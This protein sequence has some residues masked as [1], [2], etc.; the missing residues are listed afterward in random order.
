MKVLFNIG[1][2]VQRHG[3]LGRYAEELAG[4]LLA[5]NTGDDLRLFYNDPSRRSPSPPL[6]GLPRQVLG[7]S[8]KFWRMSA[9]ISCYAHISMDSLLGEADVFHATDHLLPRLRRMRSVFTLHDLAFLRVPE[10]HLPLNRWFLKLMMPFFLRQ[11]DEIISVSEYTKRDAVTFYGL[12]ES[13]VQVIPEGVNPRFVPVR[14]PQRLAEARQR[15]GLPEKFILFVSTIEPR[16]NLVTLWEAY[17]ALRSEGR[18]E[19]LVVVGQKGWLYQE[20]MLRLREVGLEEQVV[21]PGYVAEE[22]LPVLYSLADCFAFPSL[23]EGFGLTPLEAMASGCPVVCSN[24]SSLPEVCGDATILV[25][26]MDVAGL[27]S[28]LRRVLN[29]PDLQAELRNKG[30]RQAARF[31]WESAAMRTLEV[32]KRTMSC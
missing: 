17:R 9:L 14:D 13:K 23:F 8:N 15:Y 1:P 28:S 20:T 12:D 27:V 16:K 21:F 3:G 31:T 19:G 22:D 30:I 26:P 5:L 2:A 18:T 32:Y 24:S 25:A 4:A 10:T 11:A 7:W 6:D 29:E